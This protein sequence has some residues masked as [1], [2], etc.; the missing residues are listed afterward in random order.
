MSLLAR[1]VRAATAATAR[2]HRRW[3]PNHGAIA[4]AAARAAAFS[5]SAP[6]ARKGRANAGAGRIDSK[7][8]R[9][10][11]LLLAVRQI[12]QQYGKG[13]LMRL[14]D[15]GRAG[16]LADAISTGSLGL[17]VALGC[18]GLPRGRIVEIYGPEASGKTTL[19]LH[20]VAAAQ[21]AGGFAC[22][23]DAE[24]ALD[25]SYARAIGVDTDD[26]YVAQ[27]DSGE[28][29][30]EIADTL[31]RSGTMDVV[32]VDS[33]AALTPRA[34]IEGEMARRITHWNVPLHL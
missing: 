4:A 6:A 14:G 2:R 16:P 34:E 23:V 13:A 18:G 19:A 7:E 12:E 11:A 17:D 8:A 1:V 21:R 33:V 31:V 5:T 20:T 27:P 30:L 9:G 28:Q 29:A 15:H 26:L 3:P 25:P 10:A 22:F 24:H 32:V